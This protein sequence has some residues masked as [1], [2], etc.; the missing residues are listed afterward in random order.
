M[1]EIPKYNI[2]RYGCMGGQRFPCPYA[3]CCYVGI[4]PSEDCMVNAYAEAT[5]TKIIGFLKSKMRDDYNIRLS[6]YACESIFQDVKNYVIHQR[7]ESG[8]L[9]DAEYECER[10]Y[11]V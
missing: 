4:S 9:L 7:L 10:V 2:D 6:G 1:I 11:F 5:A 3:E 8:E